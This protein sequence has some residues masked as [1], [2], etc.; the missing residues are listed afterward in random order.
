MA[1]HWTWEEAVKAQ[2][3]REQE[4]QRYS[5][6]KIRQ[7]LMTPLQRLIV[8]ATSRGGEDR[9]VTFAGRV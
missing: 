2:E 9:K 5:T 7:G 8:S 4:Q 1:K 3:I 6:R